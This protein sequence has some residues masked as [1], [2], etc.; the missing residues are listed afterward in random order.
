MGPGSRSRSLSSGRPRAGPVGSLVR[1]DAREAP[2][3][4]ALVAPAAAG[5]GAILVDQF[6]RRPPLERL[7]FEI[8]RAPVAVL[9]VRID[10][11]FRKGGHDQ[12]YRAGRPK[13]RNRA[14]GIG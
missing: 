3:P 11:P 10:L 14:F 1:D 9:A 4:K 2:H 8:Q 5:L 6:D 7:K 13:I 12:P